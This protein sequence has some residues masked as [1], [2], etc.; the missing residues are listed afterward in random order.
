[1]GWSPQWLLAVTTLE[2]TEHSHVLPQ[3]MIVAVEGGWTKSHLSDG[4]G[5]EL[6]QMRRASMLTI[7]VNFD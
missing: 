4:G 2:K 1:M 7:S 5:G 3:Q 6:P